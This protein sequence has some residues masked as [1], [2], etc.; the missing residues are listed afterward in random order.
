MNTHRLSFSALFSVGLHASV[1]LAT[2]SMVF[3]PEAVL[4]STTQLELMIKS[5]FFEES[6]EKFPDPL[7]Q[8]QEPVLHTQGN[9][10]WRVSQDKASPMLKRRTVSAANH[11]ARDADY[12]A[13]W[14][15]HV[16]RLGTQ[17]YQAQI[18]QTPLS[19]EVRVL[20]SIGTEGQLVDAQVR[21]SSG[22]ST[23]DAMALKIVHQSAPFEPLPQ[24]IRQDTEVLEIIRTWKFTA[25]EGLRAG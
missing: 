13:R 6:K 9:A 4:R 16:E 7:S 3:L 23:L 2:A 11:E 24:A 14:R 18:K 8:P 25:H 17:Y 19:G 21:Q 20:V 1:L 22:S 5:N 10:Q 15:N 12:L